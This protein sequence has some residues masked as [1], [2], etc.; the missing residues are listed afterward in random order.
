MCAVMT[1][2][3]VL[4]DLW[5]DSGNTYGHA[6]VTDHL[7]TLALAII[8]AYLIRIAPAVVSGIF[9]FYVRDHQDVD[10]RACTFLVSVVRVAAMASEQAP[11]VS[12]RSSRPLLAAGISAA[13][14]SLADLRMRTDRP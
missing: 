8:F 4:P 9:Q 12:A 6:R 5:A 7:L 10:T 3:Q 13:L 11:F 2:T 1:V 14:A